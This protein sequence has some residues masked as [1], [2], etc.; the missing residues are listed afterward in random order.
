MRGLRLRQADP[1]G[2]PLPLQP[3]AH[4]RSTPCAAAAAV[5]CLA[6]CAAD[7]GSLG[8]AVARGSSVRQRPSTHGPTGRRGTGTD[9]AE[10]LRSS[11]SCLKTTGN[12]GAPQIGCRR[13]MRAGPRPG[14]WMA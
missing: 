11:A 14:R 5:P 12:G 8:D 6:G 4:Q 2:A 1:R 10:Q 3:C 7:A 9:A 13:V